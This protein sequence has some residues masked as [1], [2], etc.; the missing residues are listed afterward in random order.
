MS[1]V[2][3]AQDAFSI[4]LFR[5]AGADEYRVNTVEVLHPEFKHRLAFNRNNRVCEILEGR[6]AHYVTALLA[7]ITADKMVVAKPEEIVDLPNLVLGRLRM[8]V[9]TTE[10]GAKSVLVRFAY[11]IGGVQ[12]AFRAKTFFPE[13]IFSHRERV[14]VK[15]LESICLPLFDIL[16][17]TGGPDL[18]AEAA[19]PL[20][21]RLRRIVHS[22]DELR[23]YNDLLVRYV[24]FCGAGNVR[25]DGNRAQAVVAD[26]PPMAVERL[27]AG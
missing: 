1:K 22:G 2:S 19:E 26:E 25:L 21:A 16:G 3:Q 24:S 9:T 23:F 27:A 6:L 10:K 5:S 13:T 14:A 15:A 11:F 12:A 17:A 20:A 4:H 8:L 7:E 18:A